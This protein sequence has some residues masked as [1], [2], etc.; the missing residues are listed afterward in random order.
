[1]HPA[2]AFPYN[3][4][5][6]G[7]EMNIHGPQTEE[8]RAEAEVLLN[9]ANNLISP[10]NNSN[11]LGCIGDAISGNF[12]LSESELSKEDDPLLSK[13]EI[14]SRGQS[15]SVLV[16]CNTPPNKKKDGEK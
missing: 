14:A 15:S 8:A 1:M 5:F 6:D 7:D 11:V 16:F 4:D 2:V 9:V 13:T 10:K 12:I 3:A